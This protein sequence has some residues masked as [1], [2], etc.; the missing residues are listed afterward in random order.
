MAGGI[1]GAAVVAQNDVLNLAVGA[2]R[3]AAVL[4][5]RHAS[6]RC[7]TVGGAVGIDGCI[8]TGI[9]TCSNITCG[10]SGDYI[11]VALN[12]KV[13]AWYT[14]GADVC[15]CPQSFQLH[16]H[17]IFACRSKVYLGLSIDSATDAITSPSCAGTMNGATAEGFHSPGIE[18]T[19]LRGAIAIIRR[20][21]AEWIGYSGV[22]ATSIGCCFRGSSSAIDT[23]QGFII[24]KSTCI[25]INTHFDGS[26]IGAPC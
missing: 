11:E 9:A 5:H 20:T 19:I 6:C 22:G 12:A 24:F 18:T 10:T 14:A 17:T 13:I 25:G 1:D 21:N 15:P 26:S 2:G 23:L 3:E 4:I 8:C 7:G 16:L